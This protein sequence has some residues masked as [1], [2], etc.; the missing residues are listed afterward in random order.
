MSAPGIQTAAATKPFRREAVSISR[1]TTY[2][3]NAGRRVARLGPGVAGPLGQ[4]P[5][6]LLEREPAALR[7]AAPTSGSRPARAPPRAARRRAG[8]PPRGRPGAAGRRRPQPRGRPACRRRGDGTTCGAVD[9][10]RGPA[11]RLGVVGSQA[12]GGEEVDR[13][14]IGA[15]RVEQRLPQLLER[16]ACC[17]TSAA[18]PWTSPSARTSRTASARPWPPRRPPASLTRR[19]AAARRRSARA[20]GSL[21]ARRSRAG[22]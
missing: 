17:R 22:S 15:R 12:A 8:R 21:A 6:R 11:Q 13:A 20:R 2:G 7:A 18:A 16:R 1:S 4:K 5:H 3:R 19:P 10:D 14:R 9:D